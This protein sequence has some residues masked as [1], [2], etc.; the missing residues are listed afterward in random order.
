MKN[1]FTIVMAI[2]LTGCMSGGIRDMTVTGTTVGYELGNT[3][4]SL[5]YATNYVSEC[6]PDYKLLPKAQEQMAKY[7]EDYSEYIDMQNSLTTPLLARAFITCDT[8]KAAIANLLKDIDI[9]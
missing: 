4:R 3:I 1:I 8:Q 6:D 5:N 7:Y 9:K 2:F